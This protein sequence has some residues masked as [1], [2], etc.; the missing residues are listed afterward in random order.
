MTK[1]QIQMMIEGNAFANVNDVELL[2]DENGN[3][4]TRVKLAAGH[5]NPYGTAHGGLIYT[6]ADAAAGFASCTVAEMPVTLHSDFHFI[7]NVKEGVI[8]AK[9]E[10]LQKGGRIILLRVKVTSDTGVLLGEGTFT[11][12]EYGAKLHSDSGEK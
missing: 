6:M 1:E 9:A 7:K 4:L 12:Y 8:T 2:E 5:K 3:Y 11:Y 10:V